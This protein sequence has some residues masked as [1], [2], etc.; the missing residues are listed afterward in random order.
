MD[1]SCGHSPG[2]YYVDFGFFKFV[3]LEVIDTIMSTGVVNGAVLESDRRPDVCEVFVV[4]AAPISKINANSIVRLEGA[5]GGLQAFVL[6]KDG[7]AVDY[8]VF[9]EAGKK[10]DVGQLVFV[11]AAPTQ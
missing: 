7:A 2:D 1:S 4:G 9:V 11:V 10:V 3:Q 5:P 8:Q 6:A